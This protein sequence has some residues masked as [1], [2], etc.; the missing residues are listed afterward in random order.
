MIE[1][2]TRYYPIS[3]V[4]NEREDLIIDRLSFQISSVC[5]V[6]WKEEISVICLLISRSVMY[7]LEHYIKIIE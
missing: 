6:R 7:N 1:R 3:S 2:W 4:Y 5:I